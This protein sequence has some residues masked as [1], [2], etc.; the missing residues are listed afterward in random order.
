MSRKI[1]V[2]PIVKIKYSVEEVI[3]FAPQQGALSKKVME[4]LNDLYPDWESF[5]DSELEGVVWEITY[6]ICRTCVAVFLDEGQTLLEIDV[7]SNQE[8]VDV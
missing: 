3:D 8:I 7:C 4:E 2:C 6:D 1:S 5:S